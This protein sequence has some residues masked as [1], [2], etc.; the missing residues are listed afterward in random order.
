M[1]IF[2]RGPP[3]LAASAIVLLTLSGADAA[4]ATVNGQ[5]ARGRILVPT[6][7]NGQGPCLMLL[8]LGVRHPVVDPAVVSVLGLQPASNTVKQ[9]DALG[10]EIAASTVSVEVRPAPQVAQ[11]DAALVVNLT[12]ISQWL[13][14]E[15]GGILPAHLPGYEIE[16]DLPSARVTWRGLG[17]A[18]L[19]D[20]NDT[21]TLRMQVDPG[22]APIVH[23]LID[24]T[25]LTPLRL[26]FACPTALGL[27]PALFKQLGL[28]N[29]TP[30]LRLLD[31]TQELLRLSHVKLGNVVVEDPLACNL[32]EGDTPCAGLELLQ[33]TRLTLNFEFGLCRIEPLAAASFRTP[34]MAGFGVVP[35][36][37][38]GGFWRL[39][40]VDQSPAALAGLHSGDWLVSVNSKSAEGLSYDAVEKLLATETG[41]EAMIAI[42]RAGVPQ[43]VMLVAALLL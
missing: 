35:Q 21:Q 33:G 28:P 43:R 20:A 6:Y 16:I 24:H 31:N 4:G 37:I 17:D 40:V 9:T 30:R 19:Q 34:P 1:K 14:T 41:G 18:R 26:D 2:R 11:V 13:G 38:E 27:T 15:I 8:D 29:E 23:A 10:R 5:K 7:L 22:G 39:Q 25:T 36:R 42:S 32:P 3:L 12:A